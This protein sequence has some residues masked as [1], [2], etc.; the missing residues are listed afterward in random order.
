[1]SCLFVPRLLPDGSANRIFI[2]RLKDKSDNRS[3]A[4][5]EIEYHDTWSSLFGEGGPGI[6]EIFH[7][8]S[9]QAGFCSVPPDLCGGPEPALNHAQWR[10]H[11]QADF[12]TS[13]KPNVLAA[14][15]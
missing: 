8:A 4:S 9:D 5:S 11:L 14:R 2:Q 3:N 10:R 6:R 7:I 12:R 15:P 13:A 1:M